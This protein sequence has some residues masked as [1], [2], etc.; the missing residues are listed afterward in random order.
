MSKL[1][2]QSSHYQGNY[3]TTERMASFGQQF[4]T[5]ITLKPQHVIEIGTGTGILGWLLTR[6]N[7]D[8]E[9]VDIDS[10]L[11]PTYVGS[12][13]QLPI[14]TASC[15]CA[16]CF[17]V[18]EHL[19]FGDFPKAISELCRISTKHVLISIPEATPWISV[20]F[21]FILPRIIGRVFQIPSIP[22]HHQFRGEHYWEIGR[23]ETPFRQV[24]SAI[25]SATKNYYLASSFRHPL[26]PGQRFFLLE[27]H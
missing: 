19:P 20:Q 25:K 16:C 15:D 10:E 18:L 4:S 8:F 9:S 5:I 11:N 17:Q 21:L 1:Q 23:I 12:V 7:I 2:V 14:P 13:L 27:K 6:E 3:I 24:V 22:R 26:N